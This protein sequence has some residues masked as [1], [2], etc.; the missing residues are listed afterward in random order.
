MSCEYAT[1]T[2]EVAWTRRRL[3]GLRLRRCNS[4]GCGTYSVS[5][6]SGASGGGA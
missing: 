3:P 5:T 1:S 2:L 6:G 4:T